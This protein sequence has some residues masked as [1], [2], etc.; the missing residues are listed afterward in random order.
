VSRATAIA[1]AAGLCVAAP[2]PPLAGQ[3]T[4]RLS[5]A[6]EGAA[7]RARSLIAT[8]RERLDGFLF[9]GEGLLARGRG[10]LRLRYGQGRLT[11]DSAGVQRRS[12]TDGSVLVGVAALPWLAFWAGPHARSYVTDFGNQRWLYW[13][14]R[15]SANAQLVPGQLQ[16]FFDG[17]VAVA[18]RVNVP[19]SF[20]SARG[21]EAGVIALIAR[22]ALRLRLTYRID[23]A[24][25][26]AGRRESVE[27][28]ALSIGRDLR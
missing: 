24:R 6:G 8:G 11:S 7:V 14:A 2:P 15:A 13:E 18:G 21:A 5:A 22:P 16:S 3:S 9:T 27:A 19:E 10:L 4:L 26:A 12:L 20:G 17:W 23:Q 25:L 1:L 28:V